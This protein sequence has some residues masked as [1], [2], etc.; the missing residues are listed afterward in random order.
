MDQEPIDSIVSELLEGGA[1]LAVA[2]LFV[3]LV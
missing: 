1:F 3:F 2:F